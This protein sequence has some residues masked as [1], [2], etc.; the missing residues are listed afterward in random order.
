MSVKC[1][2]QGQDTESIKLEKG[3]LIQRLKDVTQDV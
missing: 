2:L 3:K 1:I